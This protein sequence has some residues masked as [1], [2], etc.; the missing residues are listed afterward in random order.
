MFEDKISS[1][2]WIVVWGEKRMRN[3]ASI[4]LLVVAGSMLCGAKTISRDASSD[5]YIDQVILL[6]NDL[7]K[8]LSMDEFRIRL[9][10]IRNST[11]YFEF[12]VE[13]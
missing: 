5:A 10:I 6:L 7:L 9:N 2:I 1:L 8:T 11:Q 13:F 12:E 3:F 4:L